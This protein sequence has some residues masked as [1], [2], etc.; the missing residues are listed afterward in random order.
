MTARLLPWLLLATVAV[1]SAATTG[2][3][4]LLTDLEVSEGGCPAGLRPEGDSCVCCA[5]V[6][7]PGFDD[8]SH[9]TVTG[10]ARIENGSGR[11]PPDA[12]CTGGTLRQTVSIPPETYTGPLM[13]VLTVRA[14][15]TTPATLGVGLDSKWT[16]LGTVPTGSFDQRTV[17]LGAAFAGREIDLEIAPFLT[18]V[19]GPFVAGT[20]EIDHVDIVPA[21][22]EECPPGGL[23]S[24]GDFEDGDEGW[25]GMMSGGAEWF[26]EESGRDGGL[27][28]RMDGTW[29]WLEGSVYIPHGDGAASP[30]LQLWHYAPST[31]VLS[32]R[33]GNQ[34]FGAWSAQGAW[35]EGR[36]CLPP[37]LAGTRALL[38]IETGYVGNYENVGA[39]T[40]L[41]DDV[42]VVSDARCDWSPGVI[43]GDFEP[44]GDPTLARPITAQHGWGEYNRAPLVVRADASGSS[45]AEMVV[46]RCVDYCLPSGCWE[47]LY[48]VFTN[49]VGRL[50]PASASGGPALTYLYRTREEGAYYFA[51]GPGFSEPL[52]HS[53]EWQSKIQCLPE[54]NAGR[55]ASFVW[56][57]SLQYWYSCYDDPAGAPLYGLEIDDVEL[58]NHPDC[59]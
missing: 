41:L 54:G 25:T 3:H 2:C 31:V 11:L 22:A 37:W 20:I 23:V 51:N 34:H 28:A 1:A 19:C 16:D 57:V 49:G 21:T 4:L 45:F 58:V 50:P 5:I 44:L 9:W 24:N 39:F 33:V 26:V 8:D 47:P 30:A 42:A 32:V 40:M 12:A 27:V 55:M 53:A 46:G 38:R 18:G 59:P 10:A 56:E 48:T 52:P 6:Q 36:V 43:G 17:C 7:N 14:T 35:T 13:V 15:N 29:G